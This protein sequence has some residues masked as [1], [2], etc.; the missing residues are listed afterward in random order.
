[1][2]ATCDWYAGLVG[3]YAATSTCGSAALHAPADRAE[4]ESSFPSCDVTIADFAACVVAVT[5]AQKACTDTSVR[6]A[7]SSDVCAAVIPAGCF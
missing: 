3:G 2:A 1:M 4:C 6:D 7:E 5:N